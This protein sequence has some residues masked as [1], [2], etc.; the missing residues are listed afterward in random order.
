MGVLTRI[1]TQDLTGE[2]GS[3]TLP[4]RVTLYCPQCGTKCSDKG[5]CLLAFRK[6]SAQNEKKFEP[7]AKKGFEVK[8]L[9]DCRCC[10]CDGEPPAADF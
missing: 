6:V 8:L 9:V 5:Q 4:E 3:V 10:G 7:L 2:G 1:G